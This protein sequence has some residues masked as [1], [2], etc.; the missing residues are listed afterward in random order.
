MGVRAN[1]FMGLWIHGFAVKGF[2]FTIG[3]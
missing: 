3:F 1:G 2:D